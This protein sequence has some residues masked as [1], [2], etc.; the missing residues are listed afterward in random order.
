MK[1]YEI[2][3]AVRALEDKIVI[4]PE[5]GEF[6]CDM[7]AIEAQFHDLQREWGNV[8]EWIAKVILNTRAEE[9]ALKAEEDR[10]KKRREALGRK[11]DRLMQVLRRECPQTTKLGVATLTYRK[12][13]RVD[14]SDEAAAV[15]WLKARKLTDCFKQPEPTVYKTEVRKLIAAGKKVPGCAIVDDQTVS[16]R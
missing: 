6:L 16:L 8:V 1:L 15:K 2:H 13:T 5:T 10:L 7:E 3:E 11:E 12:T 9:A 14:V 4:D